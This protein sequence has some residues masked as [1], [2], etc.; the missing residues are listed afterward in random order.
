PMLFRSILDQQERFEVQCKNGET[1]VMMDGRDYRG[2]IETL[3]LSSNK[4]NAEWLQEGIRQY[5]SGEVK[6]IDEIYLLASGF[7]QQAIF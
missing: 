3:Y 4:A 7:R 2:I 5:R 1:V 6:Q